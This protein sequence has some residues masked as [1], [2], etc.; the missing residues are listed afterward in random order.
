MAIKRTGSSGRIEA[1][2]DN[3]SLKIGVYY[4]VLSKDSKSVEYGVTTTLPVA[5]TEAIAGGSDSITDLFESTVYVP[6]KNIMNKIAKQCDLETLEQ[7]IENPTAIYEGN[8]DLLKD[9]IKLNEPFTDGLKGFLS[10]LKDLTGANYITNKT[11]KFETQ[12]SY[13]PNLK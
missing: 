6:L 2:K 8:K 13:S 11:L 10:E 3:G 7:S 9:L 12:L 1:F 5:N 4:N